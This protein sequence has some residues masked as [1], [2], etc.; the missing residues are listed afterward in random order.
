MHIFIKNKKLFLNHYKIKCSIGKR[1]IKV[2]KSEGDQITPKGKFKIISFLYRKDRIPNIKS[3]IIKKPIKKN[4]GWCDDPNSKYYN[5]LIKFPFKHSAEK[6]YRKDATYDLILVLN[7]NLN[8]I[9]RGKGS[10]IFIHVAKKNYKKTLG[11][12]AVR[13]SDLKKIVKEINKSTIVN[14]S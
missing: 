12:I 3:R 6:L 1:G 11:C 7:Y 2:K 8:P 5:K 10:A 4:M 9:V 13:K 14:I